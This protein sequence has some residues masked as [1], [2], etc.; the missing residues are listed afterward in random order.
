M[1]T[2]LRKLTSLNVIPLAW[3]IFIT[4]M[5][6]LTAV[7]TLSYSTGPGV[8]QAWPILAI[9]A[10]LVAIGLG[11]GASRRKTLVRLYVYSLIIIVSFLM[12]VILIAGGAAAAVATLLWLVLLGGA[13]GERLL[14]LFFRHSGGPRGYER[15]AFAI[16]LA[17]GLYSHAVLGLALLGLLNRWLVVATLVLLTVL[18][19]RDLLNIVRTVLRLRT[20]VS[21]ILH[22]TATHW[23]TLPALAFLSSWTMLVVIEAVAPEI[24]F[25]SLNYHLTLPKIYIEEQGFVTTPYNMHSWFAMGTEMNY[26][27]G[28]LLA[29]QIAAKLTNL[30][31]LAVTCLAIYALGQQFLS[32]ESGLIGAMLYATTP[33]VA[34][35]ASTTYI[36]VAIS[37]YCL[38]TVVA[39]WQWWVNKHRAWLLVAGLLA[40]FAL[41]AK[42]NAILFLAPLGVIV[43]IAIFAD[44]SQTLKQRFLSLAGAGTM[45]LL[46]S[47]PWPAL[48]YV[49]TGN[50]VFPLLNNVFKSPLWAINDERFDWARYG[51]GTGLDSLLRLPWEMTFQPEKFANAVAGNVI[52]LGLLILPV[53]LFGR[54]FG[55]FAS[56]LILFVGIVLLAFS[57]LWAFSA[58]YLRY[59]LPVLPLVYILGGYAL[60]RVGE[61]APATSIRGLG[62]ALVRGLILIWMV[63]SL[64]LF[65]STFHLIPE[66]LPYKVAFGLESRKEFL[67]RTLPTYD[68]Y[69]YIDQ[70][71]GKDARILAIN[72]H[73]RLYSSGIVETNMG[74]YI[75]PL[76]QADSDEDAANEIEQRGFTHLL[77][78]RKNMPPHLE[79]AVI[80]QRAFLDDYTSLEYAHSRRG[81][82]NVEVYRILSG[83]ERSGRETKPVAVELIDNSGFEEVEGST[84]TAW[85]PVGSPT[86]DTS[87]S[88]SHSGQAA[89]QASA[90]SG[91]TQTVPITPGQ[92]YTL[93]QFS[94][95]DEPDSSVRL[96]I[97]WLDQRGKSVDVSNNVFTADEDWVQHELTST[98]PQGAQTAKIRVTTQAG[99]AWIDDYSFVER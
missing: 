40:G 17:L 49:Q 73:V 58:Q 72:D 89:I 83:D 9:I 97:N 93:S 34:W 21:S 42:L 37:C 38:L 60:V 32:R 63:A 76:I 29:D 13:L 2:P 25:D 86:L 68:A 33:L 59:F 88:S 11:V 70:A 36:D 62:P 54:I 46:S 6:V 52:G 98:A 53:L 28:M 90:K 16:A 48:R 7:A 77:I 24:Q 22:N 41:S 80:A 56:R 94:R 69:A 4:I 96:Q 92:I 23:F 15:A 65:L 61:V 10:T 66:K 43:A 82:D 14:R 19:W 55:R 20:G 91:Y 44:R 75:R 30:I 5:Y 1:F 45:A 71:Y 57:I 50:P 12:A 87:G 81:R 85:E 79:S 74:P 26:L 18:L 78:D 31:F 95:S 99:T 8:Q 27:L 67:S 51:I 64:P 47:A 35:E 3:L 84:P 39:T